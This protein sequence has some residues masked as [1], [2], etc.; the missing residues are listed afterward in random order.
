MKIKLQDWARQN[1]IS[2]PTA[3]RLY[4]EGKLPYPAERISER[5][6]VLTLPDNPTPARTVIYCRVSTSTQTENLTSQKLRLLEECSRRGWKVDEIVEE[7]AS[8][9]NENRKKLNR[10]LADQSYS[11]IV[12]EY[13]DRLTRSN[14]KLLESALAAQ[15]REIIVVDKDELKDDLVRDMTEVLTSYCARLYGARGAKNRAQKALKNAGE[16]SQ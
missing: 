15:G 14:F 2:H 10:L 9:L 8:G 5:I 6:I 1:S 7:I 13:R 16:S 4:K 3:Y 12:I 11:R